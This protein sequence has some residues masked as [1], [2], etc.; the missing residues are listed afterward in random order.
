M[1]RILTDHWPRTISFQLGPFRGPIRTPRVRD[2]SERIS[3]GRGLQNEYGE[4]LPEAPKFRSGPPNL[5]GIQEANRGVRAYK[6]RPG[7]ESTH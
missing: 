2:S 4:P 5:R 7:L 3:R 6:V 1:G